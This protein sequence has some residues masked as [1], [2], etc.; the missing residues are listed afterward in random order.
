MFGSSGIT[1]FPR[2]INLTKRWMDLNGCCGIVTLVHLPQEQKESYLK[3]P[4]IY[5]RNWRNKLGERKNQS[6][7]LN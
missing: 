2:I 7:V 6:T 5:L 3:L 4:S 1:A